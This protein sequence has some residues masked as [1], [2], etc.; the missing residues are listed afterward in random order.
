MEVIVHPDYRLQFQK[1][2]IWDGKHWRWK[3]TGWEWVS[4][5]DSKRTSPKKPPAKLY[6]LGFRKSQRRGK[7]G[8]I[9]SKI[10]GAYYCCYSQKNKITVVY[11]ECVP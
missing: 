11:R 6:L 2:L 10:I 5:K 9:R 7:Q 8:L 4:V 3:I 1:S